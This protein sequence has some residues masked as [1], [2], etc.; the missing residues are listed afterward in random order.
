MDAVPL[1]HLFMKPKQRYVIT[2]HPI[3]EDTSDV[4]MARLSASLRIPAVPAILSATLARVSTPP[5]TKSAMKLPK[6]VPAN[7]KSISAF[8]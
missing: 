1:T 3:A 7:P 6:S 4:S 5:I 8:T 2:A